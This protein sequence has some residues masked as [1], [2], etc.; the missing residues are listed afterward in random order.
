[1][2]TVYE[3]LNT[4]AKITVRRS[5]S[6]HPSPTLVRVNVTDGTARSP[7]HFLANVFEL[8][9]AENQF[10]VSFVVDITARSRD[11]PHPRSG[12]SDDRWALVTFESITPR[13]GTAVAGKDAIVLIK[14]RCETVV[15]GCSLLWSKQGDSFVRD[16]KIEPVLPVL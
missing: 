11:Q 12:V 2:Y 6:L 16:S 7:G 14:Y 15:L 1:M 5:I 8:D 4:T 10:E 13:H 9:F 3:E